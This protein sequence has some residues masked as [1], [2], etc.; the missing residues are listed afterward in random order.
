MSAVRRVARS[1]TLATLALIVLLGARPIS[2]S[3]IVAGY[4]LVLAAIA[5]AGLTAALRESRAASPS[6]FEAGLA[7]ERAEPTRP[8]DL[9]RAEREL[10][11]A[12][13]DARHFERRLRPMLE[14]VAAAR[15]GVLRVPVEAPTLR[16]LRR[17]IEELEA[18]EWS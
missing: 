9:V 12:T 4:A 15:G 2:T 14:E 8:P 7:K 1:V 13:S 18:L 16:D 5:M 11:L 17:M 6:R 3:T 10:L